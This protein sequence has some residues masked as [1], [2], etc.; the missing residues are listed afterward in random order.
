M[1]KVQE[2]E[3]KIIEQNPYQTRK[4]IDENSLK[5]LTRS[6]RENGLINPINVLKQG[7]KYII[8]SG[9][10]RWFCFNKLRRKTIPCIVRI[11]KEAD[12]KINMVHENLMR[13][14]LQP[15]E[16]AQ[17]IKLL[18]ADKIKT[19]KDD[20]KR[21]IQLITKLKGW[22]KR[23]ESKF[24]RLEGFDGDDIFRMD[25]VLKSLNISENNAV[26]YLS[27]LSLPRYIQDSISW[28]KGQLI[29][30]GKIKISHAE[31]LARVKDKDFQ[32][33]LFERCTQGSIIRE[34]L[35]ALVNN[36]IKEVESGE[37]KGV[38][39]PSQNGQIKSDLER[40]ESLRKIIES[41]SRYICSFRV[42]TL[43]KL[44]ETLEKKEFISDVGRLNEELLMI[45]H[46]INERLEEYGS[47]K[48]EKESTTFKLDVKNTLR[49][50]NG[51]EIK[52][53][54]R[55]SFPREISNELNL[56]KR[57]ILTVKI[58]S[59]KDLSENETKKSEVKS[60]IS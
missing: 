11:G 32:K 16:K 59:V 53:G 51:H 31:Q 29:E 57:S 25:S 47:H 45:R 34:R 43:K 28:K 36:H 1:M 9:H 41:T 20:P 14:D 10:R 19:T 46:L 54:K 24:D 56:G 49:Y 40:L 13:D 8:L 39:K 33:Y 35:R 50:R 42:T 3:L 21:M 6:I 44:E 38:Y 15:I 48:T 4:R 5:V 23:G 27:V 37:F 2:I 12:F 26:V 17:T 22:K 7:D 60:G 52:G 18:I 58:I 55:F 30:E